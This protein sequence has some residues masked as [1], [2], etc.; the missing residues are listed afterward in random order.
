MGFLDP[1]EKYFISM[2]DPRASTYLW[3]FT[4]Q[5]QEFQGKNLLHPEIYQS[6]LFESTCQ[7]DYNHSLFRF[8]LR[9]ANT[10]SKL[11]N[12]GYSKEHLLELLHTLANEAYMN[13]LFMKNLESIEIYHKNGHN[14]EPKLILKVEISSSSLKKVRH[15]RKQLKKHI[16]SL[17]GW[18]KEPMKVSLEMKI[19]VT[20]LDQCD[21]Q[22]SQWHVCHLIDGGGR[23]TELCRL[24][25][26]EDVGLLPWVGVAARVDPI[27]VDQ[28][29]KG[30]VFSFLPLPLTGKSPSGLPVHVHGHFALDNMRHHVKWPTADQNPDKVSDKNLKWN[31]T[32]VEESVPE[33]YAT[34]LMDLKEKRKPHILQSALPTL[35]KAEPFWKNV[36]APIYRKIR[37]EEIFYSIGEHWV[38]PGNSVLVKAKGDMRNILLKVFLKTN[39]PVVDL[40]KHLDE[41]VR[42]FDLPFHDI[43]LNKVRDI[44]RTVQAVDDLDRNEKV[45]LLEG[46]L[47]D[48]N[49]EDLSKIPLLPLKNGSFTEFQ[50]INSSPIYVHYGSNDLYKL[51]PGTESYFVDA[52]V[53]PGNHLRQILSSS[54]HFKSFIIIL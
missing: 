28:H 38:K 36:L 52:G 35:Q 4:E 30:H 40:P 1:H 44:L 3:D 18:G 25:S 12:E 53:F 42:K 10:D 14:E 6:Q 5:G 31:L 24:S 13:L 51:L 32:L 33:V 54:M 11:S 50:G 47:V 45:Q 7:K 41:T 21:E 48:K 2:Q 39:Q 34:L 43:S 29:S 26:D 22:N 27:D 49:Y 20:D 19:V 46:I 23:R 16:Q 9:C 8:P 37:K 15:Q 17:H